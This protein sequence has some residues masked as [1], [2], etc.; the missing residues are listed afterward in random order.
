MSMDDWE[1]IP[2]NGA[3]GTDNLRRVRSSLKFWRGKDHLGR[4]L[5][6]L[7]GS[8]P[9]SPVPEKKPAGLDIQ[10]ID[11]DNG[12]KRLILTLTDKD[13]TDIFRSLCADLLKTAEILSTDERKNGMTI[14]LQRI[15]RW[16]ELLTAR[17][18]NLLS[19]SQIIGLLGELLFLQDIIIPRLGQSVNA[20]A[21]WR[22]S[23]GDEQDFLFN[24][25]IFEIKTQLSTSDRYIYISSEDQLDTVSG[26]IVLCHQ[27]LSKTVENTDGAVSLASLAEAILSNLR[28][29]DVAAADLFMLGLIEAGYTTRPEYSKDI[30]KI[31]A[32]NFYSVVESFPRIVRGDLRAGVDK[33]IYRISLHACEKFR[34]SEDTVFKEIVVHAGN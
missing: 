28:S 15:V 30:Y 19:P 24:D 18:S 1:S 34:V 4:L 3:A 23:F 29:A 7:D 12:E 21:C 31:Q 2:N 25:V 33:V 14:I 16:Q 20:I 5:F 32:R 10:I 6:V 9:T 26:T 17:R 11:R 8:P 13:A 27:S 22:G